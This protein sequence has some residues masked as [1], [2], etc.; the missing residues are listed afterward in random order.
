MIIL[1]I[2]LIIYIYIAL[3]IHRHKILTLPIFPRNLYF[4][5]LFM[6]SSTRLEIYPRILFFKVTFVLYLIFQSGYWVHCLKG[7]SVQTIVCS[8]HI[9]VEPVQLDAAVLVLL[10]VKNEARHTKFNC[11]SLH[12]IGID[13]LEIR[14]N[15]R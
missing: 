6:P 1:L 11:K 12:E 14:F 13:K 8:I 9:G 2:C 10:P 4:S 3:P 15:K 5:E 7:F